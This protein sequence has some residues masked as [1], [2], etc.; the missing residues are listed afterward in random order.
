MERAGADLDIVGLQDHA[1]L[2]GPEALQRQ[3]QGLETAMPPLFGN[4]RVRPGCHAQPC[5]V[6]DRRIFYA[7][8]FF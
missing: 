7:E 1:A 2:F 3:D 4:G 8:A 5:D 6:T